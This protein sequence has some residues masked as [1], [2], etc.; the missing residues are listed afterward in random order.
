MKQGTTGRERSIANVYGR[1][2]SELDGIAI[3]KALKRTEPDGPVLLFLIL[4]IGKI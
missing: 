4:T 3:S 1:S 2:S